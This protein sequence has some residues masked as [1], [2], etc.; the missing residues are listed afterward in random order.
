MVEK[1]AGILL[2]IAVGMCVLAFPFVMWMLFGD[3][4]P[5]FRPMRHI[6]RPHENR[7]PDVLGWSEDAKKAPPGYDGAQ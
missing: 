5:R 1:L 6:A 7:N 4:G 2:V 3:N